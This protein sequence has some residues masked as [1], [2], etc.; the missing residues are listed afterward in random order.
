MPVCE[1][2][3]DTLDAGLEW[4]ENRIIARS[5]PDPSLPV[6][7]LEKEMRAAVAWEKATDRPGVL[8]LIEASLDEIQ[9]EQLLTDEV[10]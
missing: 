8:G 10:C 7:K 4:C 1:K 6:S 9:V 2:V 5:A 3:L